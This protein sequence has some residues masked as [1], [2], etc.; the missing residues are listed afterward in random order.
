MVVHAQVDGPVLAQRRRSRGPPRPPWRRTG[1]RGC[2]RPRPR[3]RRAPRACRS[4][5]GSPARLR[6]RADHRRAARCRAP[7]CWPARSPARRARDRR[8]GCSA[9]RCA[10]PP[11]RRW[12]TR[13]T[14]RTAS[15][16]SSEISCWSAAGAL[17]PSRM[18][19]SP[20]GP[21]ERLGDRLG[22]HR[23]HA[24]LR[25]A[26]DRADAEEVRLDRHAELPARRVPCDD[27]VGQS[28]EATRR[29]LDR[30]HAAAA[31]RP[32]TAPCRAGWRRSCRPCRCPRRRRA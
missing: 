28:R 3:R 14:C 32:R 20:R 25:P 4:A 13:A 10:P 30:D 19:S 1:D 9:G 27:G 15:P 7:S 16:G 2:R 31:V 22:G 17:F 11:G 21:K 26:H 18:S 8:A 12:S 24:G 29:R 5:S 6:V 23:A